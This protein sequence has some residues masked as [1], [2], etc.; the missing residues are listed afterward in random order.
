MSKSQTMKVVRG[1]MCTTESSPYA[2]VS[3]KKSSLS[4]AL[5]RP[6]ATRTTHWM[7]WHWGRKTCCHI[8]G[9]LSER[10]GEMS[11]RCLCPFRLTEFSY[12]L[13][14][15]MVNTTYAPKGTNGLKRTDYDTIG[16]LNFVQLSEL[17]HRGAF[18]AVSQS[19]I[20]CCARCSEN[21]DSEISRLPDGWYEVACFFLSADLSCADHYRN[22]KKSSRT[23]HPNSQGDLRDCLPLS[24][25]YPSQ[26]P[27]ARC[28]VIS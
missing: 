26:N 22:R 20:T 12:L 14:A 5:I 11:Y 16:A 24:L 2:P 19:F 23:K 27:I 10:P 25:E 28:L 4:C 3:G 6:R 17:R 18:S 13:H 1:G 21:K 7:I 9:E 15:S 8:H